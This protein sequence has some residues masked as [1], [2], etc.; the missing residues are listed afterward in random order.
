MSDEQPRAVHVH[1]QSSDV[2]VGQAPAKRPVHKTVFATLS[3]QAGSCDQVL[4]QSDR[5]VVAHLQAVGAVVWIAGNQSEAQNE[6]GALLNYVTAGTAVTSP[7]PIDHNGPVYAYAP[8][9][10][11]LV[12][13]AVYEDD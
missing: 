1:I 5:R 11:Q 9:A 6:T 12:I 4:P 7:W 3:L 13:T 10:A 8:S 2:P